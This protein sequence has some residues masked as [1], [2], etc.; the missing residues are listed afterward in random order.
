MVERYKRGKG[1]KPLLDNHQKCWIW[2]R[3]AVLEILRAGMWDMHEVRMSH[4]VEEALAEEVRT[5]ASDLDIPLILNDS[6]ELV[7]CCHSSEHQGLVAKMCPFPYVQVEDV[8]KGSGSPRV[9][10]ALDGIQD[11]YNFGAILR[12]CDV[13][14]ASGVLIG[15]RNQVGC[16]SSM[17]ARSSAGAVAHVPIA[18]CDALVE[19]LIELKK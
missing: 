6:D 3:H 11:P 16:V 13:F 15:S 1:K 5:R 2:G 7:K 19:G 8:S 10:I 17:V 4:E 14:A 12:S 18:K 9:V